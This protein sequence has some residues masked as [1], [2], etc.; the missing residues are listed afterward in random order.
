MQR[1][2]VLEICFYLFQAEKPRNISTMTEA[3]ELIALFKKCWRSGTNA[4]LNLEC[5]AGKVWATLNVTFSQPPPFPHQQ[6]RSLGEHHPHA[7]VGVHGELL[8]VP[9]QL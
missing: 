1:I 8:L 5:H 7:F 4:R 6:D 3:E 9:M 2:I